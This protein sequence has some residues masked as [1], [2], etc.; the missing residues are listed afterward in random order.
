MT[1]ELLSCPVV[2][3]IG[4]YAR[5]ADELLLASPWISQEAVQMLRDSFAGK[6]V[7]VLTFP[8]SVS[9]LSSL[10]LPQMQIYKGPVHAKLYI[11]R[12]N[13]QTYAS[14]FGSANMTLGDNEELIVLCKDG[15]FNDSL[16]KIFH[17]FKNRC[18]PVRRW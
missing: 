11:F 15:R 17:R 10:T 12:R 5:E 8:Q 1:F 2:E 7:T 6:R 14:I 16:T 4:R 13:N 9:S 18:D 3:S